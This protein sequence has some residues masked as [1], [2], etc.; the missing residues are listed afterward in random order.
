MLPPDLQA[1]AR[2]IA[3]QAPP[4]TDEQRDLIARIFGRSRPAA[5]EPRAA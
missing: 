5:R 2:E 4:L 3:A 1:R